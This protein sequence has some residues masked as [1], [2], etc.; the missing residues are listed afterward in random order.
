MKKRNV[1]V[2]LCLFCIFITLK[3]QNNIEVKIERYTSAEDSQQ[4]EDEGQ[5]AIHYVRVM[6]TNNNPSD[7][8]I[9]NHSSWSGL[10]GQYD[11]IPAS[12]IKF[13][14]NPS[15]NALRK[16]T[17]KI[18]LSQKMT[19][20]GPAKEIK[21]IILK[22]DSTITEVY[23]LYGEKY[24]SIKSFSQEYSDINAKELQVEAKL[25]FYYM[26]TQKIQEETFYSNIVTE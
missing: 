15:D 17:G 4:K 20:I 12:Y 5:R 14:A 3:A 2:L 9:L 13:I 24:G 23:R 10:Y 21:N 19:D 11:D 25:A 8:V 22:S 26:E 1:V 7:L 6:I 18:V 16:E